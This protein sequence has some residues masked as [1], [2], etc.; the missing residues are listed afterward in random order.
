MFHSKIAVNVIKGSG[1]KV[2]LST[3][4]TDFR[5]HVFDNVELALQPMLAFDL[6]FLSFTTTEFTN[7][8]FS[9]KADSMRFPVVDLLNQLGFDGI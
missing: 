7:H 4:F 6:L 8:K 1:M 9:I 3:L 5:F 2:P